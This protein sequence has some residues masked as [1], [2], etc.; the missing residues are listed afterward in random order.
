MVEQII[1]YLNAKLTAT[2]HFHTTYCLVEK[3]REPREDG[4]VVYPATY[5]GAGELEMVEFD[6]AGFAYFRKD[7]DITQAVDT[8]EFGQKQLYNITIPLRLVAM[9]RRQDIVTDD[10]YSPDR[11]A[12]D[13]ATLLTFKNGDLRT[14][15]NANRVLVTAANWQTDPEQI[16][17][18]ETEG[19]GRIEPDYSRAFIAMSVTVEVLADE[20]CIRNACEFDPDILHLFD[21]C[22]PSV[23]ARLTE[24]QVECLL[25]A[26]PFPCEPAN[27][28]LINTATPPATLD[29]G[30]IPSGGS[31]LIVAPAVTVLRDGLPFAVVPSSETVDV[32]SDCA[33]CADATVE[34]NG[35][36][37]AT[38]A[39]GGTVNIM[40]EQDGNPVGAF[41]PNS[42]SW[43]IP[44]CPQ[45]LTLRVQVATGADT[46]TFTLT[47]NEAGTIT[48]V[49]AGG[50]TTFVLTV[51]ANPVTAPFTLA[52]GDVLA[53][54]FDTAGADTAVTL[55]GTY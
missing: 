21:F 47:A 8:N 9:V 46:F 26:L 7:G 37:V 11:L 29:S 24:R 14:G 39:S 19:T 28:T 44:S 52:D 34:L 55:T 50:L 25:D 41:D 18:D 5:T 27:F 6:A 35:D 20:G 51:N 49:N 45:D 36:E 4:D 23:V 30:S 3:K 53:A 42:N 12:R 16:W 43:V 38:V 1:T 13:I 33:P 2:G 15:L 40:V 32:P 17:S 22:K 10:A 48:S 31:E 54:T